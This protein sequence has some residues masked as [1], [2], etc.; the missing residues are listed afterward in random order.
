MLL[1]LG[2][3]PR[4]D[5]RNLPNDQTFTA[6]GRNLAERNG[7]T[8]GQFRNGRELLERVASAEGGIEKCVIFAHGTPDGIGWFNGNAGAGIYWTLRAARYWTTPERFA[9]AIGEKLT[10]NPIIGL[11]AC[12]CATGRRAYRDYFSSERGRRPNPERQLLDRYTDGALD[13]FAANMRDAL[14]PYRPNV[15]VRAHKTPG[16]T[17]YNPF[18]MTFRGPAGSPGEV[19]ATSSL[20]RLDEEPL[21]TYSQRW[22]ATFSGEAAQEWILGGSSPTGATNG[23]SL[24]RIDEIDNSIPNSP[25]DISA[26]LGGSVTNVEGILNGS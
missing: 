8:F 25:D 4:A 7:A 23:Q 17:T 6:V 15:E 1:Y 24:A 9:E 3:H 21:F 2:L 11:A 19:L 13:S 16:H 14:V 10:E 22:D 18:G 12:S 20:A 26:G 5:P